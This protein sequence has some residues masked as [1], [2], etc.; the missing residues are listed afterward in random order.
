MTWIFPYTPKPSQSHH[1]SVIQWPVYQI[2]S[3]MTPYNDLLNTVAVRR[4]CL[5]NFC[6]HILPNHLKHLAAAFTG[7]MNLIPYVD[8]LVT[9]AFKISI[10][11]ASR[12]H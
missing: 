3:I 6:S 4:A 8:R 1:I 5:F 10:L 7:V 9:Q 2:Q 11:S 12:A